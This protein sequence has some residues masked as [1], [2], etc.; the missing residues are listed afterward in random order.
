[1]PCTAQGIESMFYNNVKWNTIYKNIE[2]LCC[3]P[4]TKL[5]CKSTTLQKKVTRVT[6]KPHMTYK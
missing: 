6:Y 2:P 3:T 5:P 1:M 4:E